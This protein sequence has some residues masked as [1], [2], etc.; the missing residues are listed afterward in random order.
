[1]AFD[2]R[3]KFDTKIDVDGFLNGIKNIGSAAKQGI[4]TI[5]SFTQKGIS[6]TQ[7]LVKSS[8][9]GISSAAEKSF[10]AVRKSIE[11]T[12]DG[13]KWLGEQALN[14]SKEAVS[15]GQSFEKSMS[16]VI[17]TMGV[18]KDNTIEITNPDGTVSVVNTY[19]DAFRK[20]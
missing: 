6:A 5:G 11:L 10:Q 15:M 7:D 3:L 13:M 18:T 9:H 4:S 14:L 2:G 19:G 12:K 1:M 17:A 16:Q 20:S 8:I